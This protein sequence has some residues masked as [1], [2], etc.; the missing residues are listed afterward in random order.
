MLKLKLQYFGHLM[1]RVDSLEKTLMLGGIGGKRRRGWTEDEMAGWHHWLDG[2]ESEWTPGV[3][4]GQGGLACSIHGF[5]K[6]RT[7]LSDWTELNWAHTNMLYVDLANVNNL[8]DLFKLFF[9]FFLALLY[10]LIKHPGLGYIEVSRT[11]KLT[12]IFLIHLLHKCM[13]HCLVLKIRMWL[14]LFNA[15]LTK[16]CYLDSQ[17]LIN[18]VHLF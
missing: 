8:T 14:I 15:S 17:I 16:Q 7:W 6:S 13:S 4:D 12:Y 9:F 11:L 2:R 10:T 1:R 3:G 18:L 5:A